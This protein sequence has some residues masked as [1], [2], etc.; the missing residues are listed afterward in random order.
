M[1]EYNE[2]AKELTIA[3]IQNLNNNNR[4][5]GFIT[6]KENP[7]TGVAEIYN[8]IYNSIKDNVS[9]KHN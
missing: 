8:T 2:I 5:S 6:N 7:G 3:L 4:V 9:I 1:A